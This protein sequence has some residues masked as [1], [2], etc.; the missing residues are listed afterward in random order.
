MVQIIKM[1]EGSNVPIHSMTGFMLQFNCKKLVD[2]EKY[3]M[4]EALITATLNALPKNDYILLEYVNVIFFAIPLNKKEI[5]D[6][7]IEALR[8]KFGHFDIQF[9]KTSDSS[10]SEIG[11]RNGVISVKAGSEEISEKIGWFKD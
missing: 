10:R 6:R 9:T 8:S 7:L 5:A 11:V 3:E 4:A 1:M 2:A